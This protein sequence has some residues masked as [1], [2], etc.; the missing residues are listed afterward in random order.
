MHLDICGP[1]QTQ[2]LKGFKYFSLFISDESH[3][4]MIYFLKHKS[5]VFEKFKIYKA[6]ME[7]QTRNNLK[8][9]R[10]NGEGRGGTFPANLMDFV[11]NMAFY[12][13]WPL[14]ILFSKMDY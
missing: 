8:V 7:K 6:F 14:Q 5:E 11:K 12:I 1:I 9:F 2:L 4:T 10:F 3:Y 13:N